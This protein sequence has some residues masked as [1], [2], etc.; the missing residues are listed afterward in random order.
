LTAARNPCLDVF[1]FDED[2]DVDAQDLAYLLTGFE[3]DR[4]GP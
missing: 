4:N 1:G 2:A 3:S